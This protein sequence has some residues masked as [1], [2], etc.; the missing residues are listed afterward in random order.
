MQ[1]GLLA[2]NERTFLHWMNMSVTLGSICAALLGENFQQITVGHAMC[3]KGFNRK[4]E[5]IDIETNTGL[6][7]ATRAP[8]FRASCG[9]MASSH[10]D[11]KPS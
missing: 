11:A 7:R 1:I 3:P 4:E 10:M 5:E 9:L 8:F 2:A 6:V